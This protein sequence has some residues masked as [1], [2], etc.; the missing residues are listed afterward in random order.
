MQQKW[1]IANVVFLISFNPLKV[2]IQATE[3]N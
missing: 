1:K 3:L 2:V